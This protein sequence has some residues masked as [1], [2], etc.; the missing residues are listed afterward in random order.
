[1]NLT[2]IVTCG[3]ATYRLA[4]LGTLEEGPLGVLDL[5]RTSAVELAG[6]ISPA[7]GKSAAAFADCQF[8]Q[9]VW[10]AGLT[11]LLQRTK[12]GRAFVLWMAVAGLQDFLED[13]TAFR[14]VIMRDVPVPVKL[15]E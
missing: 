10:F 14:H 3:L 9:G 1:M 12:L 4:Q 6:R 5:V 7:V 2:E 8:C 11:L 15:V 13:A